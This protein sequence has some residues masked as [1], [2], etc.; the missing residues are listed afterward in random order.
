[1]TD[2]P[3]EQ[4]RKGRPTSR[5]RS[6]ATTLRKAPTEAERRLWRLLRERL[7]LNGTHF[8]R[9]A[10]IG[11]YV[12]DFCALKARLVIEVDGNQH[13]EGAIAAHDLRRDAF[14]RAEG[15]KVLRFSNRQVFTEPDMVIDTIFAALGDRA[16]G[17][18]ASD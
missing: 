13:G 18:E 11:P 10:P 6:L 7:P 12:A 1:M 15:F 2:A 4:P 14:L 5:A 8:R 9:Q 3:P 16:F 17:A